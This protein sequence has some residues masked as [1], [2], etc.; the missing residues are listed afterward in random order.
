MTP[1]IDPRNGD[2]ENDASSS[3]NR[4]ILSL[5]GSLVAEISLPKLIVAWF[6]LIGFPALMLGAMPIAVSMWFNLIVAK[7][8]SLLYG[9]VLSLIHI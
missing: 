2:F 9:L 7:F 3:K 6:T 5:A 4:S 8:S 1:F